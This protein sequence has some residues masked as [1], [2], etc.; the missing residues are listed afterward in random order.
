MNIGDRVEVTRTYD[1]A[2]QGLIGTIRTQK[3][4]GSI[5]KGYW[6]VEFTPPLDGHDLD[7]TISKNY[8]QWV[9]EKYL[10]LVG[11]ITLTGVTNLSGGK[12]PFTKGERV[13]IKK[14]Y[15]RYP[16]LK[17][18]VIVPTR[19]DMLGIEIDEPFYGHNLDDSI[20][21]SR[22]Y[23]IS[24]AYLDREGEE[25]G[26]VGTCAICQLECGGACYAKW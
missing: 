19:Q 1:S 13:V 21:S 7:G 11:S 26:V 25:L 17:G 14:E 24:D 8:G 6:G 2:K 3:T 20:T 16:G 12:L 5:F 22:G 10:K 15:T 23:W 4:T 18:T 9:P